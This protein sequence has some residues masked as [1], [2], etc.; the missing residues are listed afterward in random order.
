M[1]RKLF[2]SLSLSPF[3]LYT[4][5]HAPTSISERLLLLLPDLVVVLLLLLLLQRV[6]RT[7]CVFSFP[8]KGLS[9]LPS[10]S[11]S[12]LKLSSFGSRTHIVASFVA[13]GP[14]LLL[15]LLPSAFTKYNIFESALLSTSSYSPLSLRISPS[16]GKPF[17]CLH[18]TW[19]EEEVGFHV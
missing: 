19:K 2:A 11:L 18:K 1:G 12:I 5:T 16:P 4:D 8:T 9:S 13:V 17:S 14:L 7:A 15:L 3:S 10:L 6:V